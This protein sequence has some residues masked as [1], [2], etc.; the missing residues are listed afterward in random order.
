MGIHLETVTVPLNYLVY[1][2]FIFITAQVRWNGQVYHTLR[3]HIGQVNV[4]QLMHSKFQDEKLCWTKLRCKFTLL[5]IR[6]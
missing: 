1:I 5:F 2:D 3:A 4:I 6:L